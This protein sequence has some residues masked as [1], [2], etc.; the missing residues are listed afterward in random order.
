MIDRIPVEVIFIDNNPNKPALRYGIYDE[1][2]ELLRYEYIRVEDN[3][4]VEGTPINKATI[5]TDSTAALSTFNLNAANAI[6][7]RA[8]TAI[9]N[10]LLL[11]APIASPAFTGTPTGPTAAAGTDTTQFAT[12][13]FVQA[14][15]ALKANIASPDFTGIPLVDTAAPGTNTRQAASTAFVQTALLGVSMVAGSYSGSYSESVFINL[16][17]R[18]KGVIVKRQQVGGETAIAGDGYPW[19]PPNNS[20]S[21]S[22]TGF[23]ISGPFLT[24]INY[25]YSYLAWRG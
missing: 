15:G 16:G 14:L 19:N 21:I 18:P 17:F 8:F 2:G 13:A 11:K 3:A 7:D 6:P 24:G 23:G 5:L 25:S 4:V 12:T 22:A 10:Q 9:H 20:L 1:T